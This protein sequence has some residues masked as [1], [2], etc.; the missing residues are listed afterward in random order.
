M[1]PPQHPSQ[2]RP[3]DHVREYRILRVLGG[4]GFSL[5]FLVEFHGVTY[6]M[7]MATTPASDAGPERVDG[8]MR[9]EVVSLERIIHPHLL[10]VYE[11]GRWPDPRTGYSFYVTD[12]VPGVTFNVWRRRSGATPFEWVGVL[13]DVL[14]PLEVLHEHGVVHRDFKA[15]NVL[16]READG[17]PFLIDLGS[18]HLPGA[19]PLTEG[20][21]PGTLYCQPPEAVAFLF[22]PAALEPESRLEAHPSADL[23]GVGVLLYEALTDQY[24]FDPK[25]P[26][27]ELLPTILHTTP[28]DPGQL[29]PRAPASLVALCLRL[30]AKEPQARPPSVRAVREELER[31]R[32]EEGHTEPWRTPAVPLPPRGPPAQEEASAQPTS[33]REEG[34]AEKDERASPH[35][36][37]SRTL[38]L[39]VLGGGLLLALG[40]ML[41]RGE[42]GVDSWRASLLAEPT[43]SVLAP[44]V[45]A[46][47]APS[48]QFPH[49][50][51]SSQDA[52][53]PSPE[54][55]SLCRLLRAVLGSMAVAQFVGCA[56]TPPPVRPDPLD[57]LARCSTEAR[58]TP[59]TLGFQPYEDELGPDGYLYPTFF[60]TGTPASSQPISEGGPLNIRSG[61]ILAAMRPLINGKEDQDFIVAG[62]AFVTPSRV[63]IEIDRIQLPDGSWL[64]LCG[65]AVE[66]IF[67]RNL[68]G[69]PTYAAE[70]TAVT[71]LDPALV[72]SRPGSAVLNHPRFETFV[73]P[74]NPKVRPSFIRMPPAEKR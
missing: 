27:N 59:R 69:V 8:W 42:Q 60:E 28:P 64:P 30:L 18:V 44:A 10:P 50:T 9:R 13:C 23:Y 70:P 67:N 40:W 15:D 39:L 12:Y 34:K 7:K 20:I 3:G 5:V 16:V 2:L 58:I 31:L 11:M 52:L 56:T 43:V 71:P 46:E 38:A 74:A 4:G 25:L 14:R 22:S 1:S 54:S 37:W 48:M 72:D 32:T 49:D 57:Y 29:N 53:S 65:V 62:E 45:R 26:L 19:R 6:A 47:G 68:F 55:S 63:Y 35:R 41:L 17:H 36:R 73:Q 33:S 61:P 21:A 51:H 66:G 24:P